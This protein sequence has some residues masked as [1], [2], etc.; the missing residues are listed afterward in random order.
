MSRI[1]DLSPTASSLALLFALAMPAAALELSLPGGAAKTAERTEAF[2][3]LRLPSGPFAAG[4]LPSQLADGPLS[5][6]AY[7]LKLEDSSTAQVM[8]DLQTQIT[9]AGYQ[10]EFACETDACGGYDFRYGTEVLAEPDMHV[11]LADFR[12]LLAKRGGGSFLSLLVSRSGSAGFVQITQLGGA[13]AAVT[14]PSVASRP[15]LKPAVLTPEPSDL[16]ASLEAG[17]AVVLD[18][19]IFASG[20]SAL[21][22]GNY[23]SLAKLAAWLQVNPAR[24][25]V[26]VGH[27]DASGVLKNNIALSQARAES[28]RQALLAAHTIAADQITAEGIGPLSPRESNLTEAGRQKNR[29]VE[30][31]VTSTDLLAP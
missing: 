1:F 12:Y 7:R 10:L 24:K 31:M 9:R 30:V 11:N 19:L 5:I 14:S 16:V 29:R 27:T 22:A 25:V 6:V 26:L 13:A 21:T 4:E 23:A 3:S 2:G 28:V 17:N 8:R 20:S 18:D 15:Q